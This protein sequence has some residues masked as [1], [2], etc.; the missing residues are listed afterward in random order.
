VAH[1][2]DPSYSG[3]RDQKDHCSKSR[4]I[5]QKTLSQKYPTQKRAG[6]VTQVVEHLPS[7]HEALSTTERERE[8]ERENTVA[9]E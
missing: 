2:C 5:V 4:E 3:V 9:T 6:R 7:K 1:T 8:S